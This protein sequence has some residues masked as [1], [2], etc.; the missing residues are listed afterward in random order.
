MVSKRPY[1][2]RVKG[3]GYAREEIRRNAGTQFDP[4]LAETFVRMIEEQTERIAAFVESESQVDATEAVEIGGF[5]LEADAIAPAWSEV[6]Q[7]RF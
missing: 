6:E 7:S 3:L 1:Q 5:P 2:S 4:Q